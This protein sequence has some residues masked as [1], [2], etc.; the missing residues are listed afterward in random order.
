MSLIFGVLFNVKWNLNRLQITIIHRF[1]LVFTSRSFRGYCHQL[2]H[3]KNLNVS[4]LSYLTAKFFQLVFF[5]VPILVYGTYVGVMTYFESDILFFLYG[6]LFFITLFVFLF[7]RNIK[8]IEDVAIAHS[9]PILTFGKV[10]GRAI[11]KYGGLRVEYLYTVDGQQ[12]RRSFLA[13]IFTQFSK[14]KKGS[15][16]PLI[17]SDMKPSIACPY[18]VSM[19]DKF[20]LSLDKDKPYS[21]DNAL[22]GFCNI[23]GI[24]NW[25]KRKNST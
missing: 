13:A 21:E 25:I 4:V 15:V 2:A 17:Y 22:T 3:E 6:T 12:H 5:T 23:L 24:P 11:S 7:L 20:C 8:R 18:D 9:S 1:F 10:T 14:W 19:C 16:F